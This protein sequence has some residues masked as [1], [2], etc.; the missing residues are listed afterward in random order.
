MTN[1]IQVWGL[2]DPQPTVVHLDGSTTGVR[3]FPLC[4]ALEG[5]VNGY[6]VTSAPVNCKQCLREGH[7]S[8]SVKRV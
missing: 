8:T 2:S 4:F 5:G 6:C 7:Q 3:R 1:I